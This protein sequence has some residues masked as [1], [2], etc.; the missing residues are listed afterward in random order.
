[1]SDGTKIEW[2]HAG[3]GR[4]ASLNPIRAINQR[5]MKQGWYCEKV[6]P[7]CDNCYAERQNKKTGASGGT[8]LPY[9]PGHRK[10]VTVFL[11]Y[12]ALV[13]MLR[14][15]DPRG[16]FW[17]SMTDLFGDFVTD[18]MREAV[19]SYCLC[20]PRHRHLFLTKRPD[21]AADF[22]ADWF[23]R[24]V[25]RN[26][27]IDHPTGAARLSDLVALDELPTTL[28]FIWIGATVEDQRRA[29]ERRPAMQK[30]AAQGWTTFV[31]YEPALGLVDWRGWEFLD[32]LIG[33]GETGAEAR[34]SRPDWF[35]AARDWAATN[36][37]A[38]HFKQWGEYL[39]VGQCLPG[40]GRVHGATA[41]KPGRMKLHY[42]GSPKQHPKHAFAEH[43]VDFASTDDGRLTFRVGKQAAGRL[44]DG[45]AHDAFPIGGPRS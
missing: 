23:K 11:H 39:P 30:L 32:W 40:C 14:W 1:M 2:A 27:W 43:G 5:T 18:E 10:D 42:G 4:G 33:G 3:L 34:L 21:R 24:V 22:L 31:S 17:C 19:L 37:I 16:I 41:V 45:R 9:K 35:R 26:A 13:Q 29:D 38:F 44:L 8:G 25:A 15:R 7:A 36:A 6:S 20:A 28:P 12:P